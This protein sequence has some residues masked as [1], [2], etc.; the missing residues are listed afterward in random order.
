MVG[1]GEDERVSIEDQ[2]HRLGKPPDI[3]PADFA[4]TSPALS[5]PLDCLLHTFKAEHE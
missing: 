5:I 1:M 2:L 4:I 3:V